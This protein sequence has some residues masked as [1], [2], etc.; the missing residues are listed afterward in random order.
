MKNRK[1]KSIY[2]SSNQQICPHLRTCTVYAIRALAVRGVSDVCSAPV[3]GSTGGGFG[4]P[5]GLT[6]VL[7]F[8]YVTVEIVSG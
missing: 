6:K 1:S 3:R 4:I 5:V 2:W 8:Y 7:V